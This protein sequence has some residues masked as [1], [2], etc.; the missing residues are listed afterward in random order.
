MQKRY[1]DRCRLLEHQNVAQERQVQPED[2]ENI[3]ARGLARAAPAGVN[4]VGCHK[5]PPRSRL[6]LAGGVVT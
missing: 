1:F 3:L 4:V 6:L 5:R 2:L